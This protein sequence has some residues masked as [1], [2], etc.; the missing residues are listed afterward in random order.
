MIVLGTIPR[1]SWRRNCCCCCCQRVKL[2]ES[3]TGD[4]T[5]AAY[6]SK[7]GMDLS[8][9]MFRSGTTFANRWAAGRRILLEILRNLLIFGPFMFCGLDS[10]NSVNHPAQTRFQAELFAMFLAWSSGTLTSSPVTSLDRRQGS[11]GIL[12]AL[13]SISPRGP[14]PE[15]TCALSMVGLRCLVLRGEISCLPR[16]RRQWCCLQAERDN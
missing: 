9:C 13:A 7:H 2:D 15:S 1:S 10:L 16:P 8:R 4:C 12:P 3:C 14:R 6:R 5:F 11:Y